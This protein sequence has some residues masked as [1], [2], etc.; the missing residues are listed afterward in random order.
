[1]RYRQQRCQIEKLL[2]SLDRLDNTGDTTVTPVAKRPDPSDAV[3]S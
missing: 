3:V 2:N 1:M